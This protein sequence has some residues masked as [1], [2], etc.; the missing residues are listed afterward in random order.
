MHAVLCLQSKQ[1]IRQTNITLH[2]AVAQHCTSTATLVGLVYL[3]V[4]AINCSGFD[5]T[6]LTSLVAEIWGVE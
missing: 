4:L 1:D 5:N 2:L 6:S 3:V